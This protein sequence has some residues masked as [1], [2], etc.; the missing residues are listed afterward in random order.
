MSRVRYYCVKTSD[1]GHHHLYI[2]CITLS[3]PGQGELE[4]LWMVD[5]RGRWTKLRTCSEGGGGQSEEKVMG[6]AEDVW[7]WRS[8]L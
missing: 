8:V 3:V 5:K 4:A 7:R 2:S 6:K 1:P